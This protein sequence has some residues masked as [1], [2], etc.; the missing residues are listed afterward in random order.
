[1]I[2]ER[3]ITCINLFNS[4]NSVEKYFDKIIELSKRMDNLSP[5]EI[6]KIINHNIT[7]TFTEED[8]K[9]EWYKILEE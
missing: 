5:T 2:E 3:I 7:D 6:S 4:C 8:K 1:M 9:K